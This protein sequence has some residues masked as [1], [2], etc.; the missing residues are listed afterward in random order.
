MLVMAIWHAKN[1]WN[2]GLIIIINYPRR[3]RQL[4]RESEPKLTRFIG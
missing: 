2:Q 4:D 1:M 3:H